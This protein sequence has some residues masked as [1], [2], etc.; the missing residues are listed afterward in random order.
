MS[1]VI[2]TTLGDMTVDLYIA[3]RPRT[4]L[5]FL[6]LCK[7]KYYNLCLFHRVEQNFIA[8]TGDPTGSGR[9]GES[10]FA[11]LYGEQARYFEAER[12]PRLKHLKLGTLSMQFRLALRGLRLVEEHGSVRPEISS[13]SA[14]R[15]WGTRRNE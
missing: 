12:K 9:G 7:L 3:E 2:E 13:G 6:K 10:L 8:Q 14:V 15:S 11:K 5:N 1:V 4:C